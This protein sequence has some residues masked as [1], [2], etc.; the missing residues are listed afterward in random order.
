MRY[1]VLSAQEAAALIHDGECLGMSGLTQAGAPKELPAALAA[2]AQAE[3]E[4]GRPFRL[5]VYTTGSPVATGEDALA[6]ASALARC[7]PFQSGCEL[8]SGINKGDIHYCDYHLSKLAQDIRYGHLP[9]VTT[10]V[11]EASEITE[12]GDI[13]LTTGVGN[14]TAYAEMCD[15]IIIELNSYH[16]P[17]LA[18]LHDLYTLRDYPERESIPIDYPARRIGCKR[19]RVAPEKIVAVVHTHRPDGIRGFKETTEVTQRIGRNIVRFLEREYVLGRLPKEFPPLQSGVGNIANAVIAALGHSAIIPPFG[20]YTE[21]LQDNV[22]E[23]MRQG[24]CLHAS[25]SAL[26]IS[27]AQMEEL[28]TNFDFYRHKII[29]RS[30]ELT[31][32]P[33]VIRRLGIISM[34]TALEADI[35][36]NVNSTH[37]FGS[38]MMNGIGGSGDYARAARLSIFSCPSTAK[39]GTISTIVP[40]VSHQDHSEH[41]V[42]ILVTEWGVADLRG[43]SPAERA[44]LIIEQC[45]H[46]DYRPMLR[47]LLALA[48]EGHTPLSLPH[49]FALHK[50]YL[51]CGDMRKAK[52]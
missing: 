2:R 23:L 9:R 16:S 41:D 30:L 47:C 33:E 39:D 38:R 44:E 4:A 49:A 6:G 27:D 17:R 24:R 35:F 50:A 21:V 13:T 14:S 43:K 22:L 48:P 25:S 42:D 10:A 11:L 1:P 12:E 15:R 52:L 37:L 32:N 34:N 45:S 31:N 8:R 28:Y 36:G 19:L 29:L 26:T 7:M 5:M 46:P 20:M 18:E 51:E 40:M 3:H